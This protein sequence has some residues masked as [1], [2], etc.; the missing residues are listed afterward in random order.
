ME[1]LHDR[2][3]ERGKIKY[4]STNLSTSYTMILDMMKVVYDVLLHF[5]AAL[6]IYYKFITDVLLHIF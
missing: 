4:F 5:Y 1:G 2:K 6:V 3:R